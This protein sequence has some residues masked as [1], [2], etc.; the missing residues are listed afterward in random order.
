MNENDGTYSDQEFALI[1]AKASELARSTG[2][3]DPTSSRLSLTEMK[4]IAAE[5]GLDPTL[6][7]RAARLTL[8]DPTG[9][10]LE[11]I[12]GGRVTHR[13]RGHTATPL[14]EDKAARLLNAVKAAAEQHGEGESSSSGVTWHSVGEGSPILLSA[15]A[16]G[17]GTHLRVIHDR[18]AGLVTTVALS[19]L[20][21]LAAGF[22]VLLGGEA[23]D[24]QSV[25]LGLSL[26]GGAV[27]S[28]LAVG[29]A[30]WASGSRRSHGRVVAL[31][32]AA[33][34][35]LEETTTD[36]VSSAM[37]TPERPA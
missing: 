2:G 12:L 1:L 6:V 10:R 33:S 30:A 26:I 36:P 22:I 3:T 23:I 24:L 35:S 18:R 29:R 20:G 5:V 11:R 9:S 34:R 7:E 25:P 28:V 8:L 14:T 31:M 32:D 19:A 21:S 4:R 16:E 15:H 13:L 37:N 17:G 27:A